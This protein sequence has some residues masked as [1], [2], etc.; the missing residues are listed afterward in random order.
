MNSEGVAVSWFA[1][2]DVAVGLLALLAGAISLR[3]GRPLPGVRRPVR[4]P[5]LHG[6]GAV[7][8]GVACLLQ[9][10]FHFGVIPSPSWEV[11]FFGANALL[12]CGLVLLMVDGFRSRAGDAVRTPRS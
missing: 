6:L 4:Q 10:F 7:L 2:V 3:T 12:L 11:R 1:G 5:R 8:I 9:G